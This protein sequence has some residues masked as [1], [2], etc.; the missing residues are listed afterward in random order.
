MSDPTSAPW[1]SDDEQRAW[2]A[3]TTVLTTVPAAIDAQLKRDSGFNFFEFTILSSL[4]QAPGRALRMN[5]LAHLACASPSR[6]SHAVS[7]LEKHD[8]VTR[9]TTDSPVGRWVEAVLT[10]AGATAVAAAAPAH[11][12]EVRRL[13]F[14]VLTP[15]QVEQLTQIGYQL[16]RAAAPHLTACME[17]PAVRPPT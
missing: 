12:R 7:R 3:L 5:S 9:R 16:L 2:M 14:D 10:D 15:E 4:T 13:V 17:V 11:V 1:L 8:W 6:L